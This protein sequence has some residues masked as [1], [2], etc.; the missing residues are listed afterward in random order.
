MLVTSSKATD[1]TLIAA[2]VAK[3]EKLGIERFVVGLNDADEQEMKTFASK[4]AS[5]HI[6]KVI[7]PFLLRR[8]LFHINLL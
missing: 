4:P 1:A 8:K 7:I 2:E 6:I 5:T 3:L